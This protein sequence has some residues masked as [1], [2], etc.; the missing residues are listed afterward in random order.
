[1]ITRTA[2]WKNALSNLVRDPTELLGHLGLSSAELEPLLDKGSR[3]GLRVPHAFL[4][5]IERGNPDDPLLRQIL[6]LAIEE[7]AIAGFSQNPVGDIQ[8]SQGAGILHKYQG[9]VLLTVTGACPIHCRYCFRRHFPYAESNPGSDDWQ[10][11][12]DY[13]REDR[14]IHELIL[15]GG[16]PLMLEHAKLVALTDKLKEIQHLRRLRIH[17]RMPV[18]IPERVDGA[19]IEWL[20]QL[21]LKPIMVIHANHPAEI[22]SAVEQGLGRLHEAGVTLLNQAVLLRG[23]NDDVVTQCRLNERLFEAHTL[24]YYLHMLDRVAG[25]AHFEVGEEHARAIM[26]GMQERLP[27][28]LV[29]RLVR[30]VAGAP[31]KLPQC[32]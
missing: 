15:S 29:P 16:D 23:V 4:D 27:G 10:V 28:Y 12:I 1:M 19:L 18:V 13:L 14:S 7:E 8:A 2:P 20:Q 11:A 22:D 9:R 26:R 30:E 24:P 5:R 32:G 21:P 31:N 25:A 3:F 17:T 6:P